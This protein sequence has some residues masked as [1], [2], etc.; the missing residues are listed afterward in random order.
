[1][2]A[3]DVQPSIDKKKTH[4]V[5]CCCNSNYVSD[6]E[7]DSNDLIDFK[8]E[9]DLREK[10]LS[11]PEIETEEEIDD[12][13]EDMEDNHDRDPVLVEE[14][15]DSYLD[16]DE[17]LSPMSQM[18]SINLQWT[19]LESLVELDTVDTDK[20]VGDLEVISE[21]K[22]N[23][24]TSIYPSKTSYNSTWSINDDCKYFNNQCHNIGENDKPDTTAE[25]DEFEQQPLEQN[26]YVESEQFCEPIK[27]IPRDIKK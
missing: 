17:D 16:D 10:V 7:V 6:T 8:S 9:E 25:K 19:D 23:N 21:L 4:C 14:N 1:M 26:N 12:I 11:H 20:Q 13:S 27:E 24:Q 5:T 3:I 15:M 18:S 2:I 22:V